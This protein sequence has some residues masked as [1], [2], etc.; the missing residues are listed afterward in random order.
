MHHRSGP[1]GVAFLGT[2]RD[3]AV[4]L[5]SRACS[6][7]LADARS[8]RGVR[9]VDSVAV[10]RCDSWSYD[11]PARR[12]ADAARLPAAHVTDSPL[13]GSQ[14]QHLLHTLCDDIAGGRMDLGLIVSGEALH[15]LDVATRAGEEPGWSQPGCRS[16]SRTP[17]RLLPR[18]RGPPRDAAH[19]AEFRSAR[20]GA[21]GAPPGRAR[22]LRREPAPTYAAMS[23]VA[24]NNPY[25]WHPVG[26]ERR[27][28]PRDQHG[29]SDARTPLPQTHDGV[30]EGE[31]GRGATRCQPR[32]GRRPRR[33]ADR[34]VYI[35]GWSGR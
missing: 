15:T 30:A 24:A 3:R 18:E 32:H 16:S 35:R 27:G 29:Q 22:V 20:L 12:L 11:E 26:Q 13:G 4:D 8:P 17:R 33:P 10:V 31:P 9:V 2:G 14:P 6:L 28:D 23:A 25:A 7:A 1:G 19:H 5:W 21:T 34:R